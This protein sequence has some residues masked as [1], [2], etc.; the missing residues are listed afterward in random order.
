MDEAVAGHANRIEVTLEPGPEG[1]AGRLI[2]SDNGRGI[3][4]DEHPK[5]PGKS[6]LEVILT[7][8]HSGGKFSGKAYATSGGLHGV[9]VS[10]VNALSSHVRVE[11]A[12]DRRLFAQEFSR[13]VPGRQ[14]RR[15]GRSAEPAG[16]HRQLRPRCRDFRR[17]SIQACPPVQAR[18]IE[19]LSLRRG[20][21]P[22]EV[23]T[24][25]RF[26]GRARRGGVPVPPAAWRIISPIRSATR[27]CV[28]TDPFAGR[29]DFAEDQGPRRMGRRLAAMVRRRD[30]LVLQHRAH[31]R[32]RHARA[33]PAR[34]SHQGPAR[35]RRTGRTEEIEGHHRRRR[36]ER[37]RSDAQRLHPRSPVPEPDQGSAHLTRGRAHGR[38]RDARPFRPLPRRQHGARQ[39]PCWAR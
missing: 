6:S 3:P 29:Q 12:R 32:R 36:D 34:R 20:G 37:R 35:L 26:G 39:K 38:D 19:G 30:E 14:D 17:A 11:V 22:L 15:S 16:H 23:R 21:D 8:L 10:V 31:A 33:G 24:L 25:A 2:V 1:S 4:V 18:P 13:G 27:E 28:T 7:T 9:G 5:F